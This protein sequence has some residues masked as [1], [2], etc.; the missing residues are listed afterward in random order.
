MR[1]FRT[2]EFELAHGKRPKGR[3][4]W[5]FIPVRIAGPAEHWRDPLMREFLMEKWEGKM[6]E[7]IFATANGMTSMTYGEA[8]KAI[9][10]SF[11]EISVWI[12]AT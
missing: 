1:E 2:E 4:S 7:P 12:V 6:G 8:K 11:P 10:A 5:A 9:S 3:G